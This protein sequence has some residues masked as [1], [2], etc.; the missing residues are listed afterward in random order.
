MIMG[1]NEKN[2]RLSL[3]A[4][5]IKL[6]KSDNTIRDMEFQ[7]LLTI[8]SQMGVTKEEFK[9]LFEAYIEFN[10]PKLEFDRIV[11]FQ[12]LV[13]LMNVDLHIDDTEILYIKDLGIRM[14]L[15]PSATNEVLK[16]M[17]DYPNKVVP[18]EKLI[19]IFRTF[20]N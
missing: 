7:F 10:P 17:N 9:D 1:E 8:A 18:P 14:G 13:L 19:Q 12:R 16:V 20:H 5:L 15:H 2:E 3:I 11:Q 4:E 6:A